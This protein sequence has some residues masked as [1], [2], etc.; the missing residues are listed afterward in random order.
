MEEKKIN[1]VKKIKV[2]ITATKILAEIVVRRYEDYT[3]AKFSA[4][5][6]DLADKL[7]I[8]FF[9]Q[10]P[11]KKREMLRNINEDDSDVK[12]FR[13]QLEKERLLLN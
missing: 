6:E 7:L 11:E 12:A 8:E 1:K 3:E 2:G 10:L 9:L 5:N 13:K 4:E